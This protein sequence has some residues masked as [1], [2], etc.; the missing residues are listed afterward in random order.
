[1]RLRLYRFTCCAVALGL[2]AV[3]RSAAPDPKLFPVRQDGKWGYIDVRGKVVIPPH[4]DGAGPFSEGLASV[5][6]GARL[7]YV[8]A[9]GALVLVPSHDPAGLLHRPFS[10]GLAA[11]KHGGRIGFMDR[12]G[13]LAVPATFLAAKDFSEGFAFACNGEACGFVDAAGKFVGSPMF[14]GGASFRNGFGTVILAMGM[15]HRRTSFVTT[16][17]RRLADVYEGSGDFSEGLAPVRVG[18]RWGY[19]DATGKPVIRNAFDDAGRFAEG[20]APVT[21]FETGRC[22]YV[23]RSGRLAIPARFA[24]CHPFSDGRARVDLSERALDGERVAFID[25]DGKV[26][27]AGASAEPRFDAAGDF[28]SGLAAVGVGGPPD[29]ADDGSAKLGYVDTAGRYVWPPTN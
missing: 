8:D 17:R 19:V 23:D 2:A 10:C 21:L 26:I 28:E 25:R 6:E 4:F 20:L 12:S 1:M 18:G 29:F 15:A 16:E 24:A 22:G 13:A 5:K 3:A 11:I 27:V 9:T 14:M 7:G